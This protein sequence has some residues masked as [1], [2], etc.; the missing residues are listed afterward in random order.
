M[1]ISNR[2]DLWCGV[3]FLVLG[4]LLVILSQAY[5]LGLPA[6][7][8]PGFFPTTLGILMGLLGIIIAWGGLSPGAERIDLETVGWRE[9]LLVLLAVGVF[10]T[11]LPYMGML[12]SV[13]LLIVISALASQEFRWR[14]TIVSAVVLVLVSELVFIRG[15]GLPLPIWPSF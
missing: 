4:G 11:A 5:E 14:D 8:G 15:L 3:M 6:R 10:A 9:L 7:M 13:V 1:K 12:M 2:R